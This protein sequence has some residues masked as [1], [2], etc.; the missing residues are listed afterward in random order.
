M[1]A[2]LIPLLQ[3]QDQTLVK[4]KRF[5]K[6]AYIGDP[7]N[8]VRI[9]NELE[10]DEMAIVDIRASLES[11]A[12]DMK[13]LQTLA[14]ECFMPLAYGGGIQSLE[15]AERI[16][17]LGFEKIIL[18]S[19]AFTRPGLMEAMAARLGSQSLVASID[20]KRGWRGR[21]HVYIE[22]GTRR[23]PV[24]VFSWVKH[25]ENAG[26]GEILLTAI[27][28][29]GSWEGMDL[30]LIGK[31]SQIVH[32]PIM[33]HGGAGSLDDICQAVDAGASSIAVGNLVVYQKKGMGVLIH[34][35]DHQRLKAMKLYSGM[36]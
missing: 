35:P 19:A 1:N 25:I 27:H 17:A 8:T 23:L 32:L 15:Q 30:E 11:R 3:V 6:P 31:V 13:W 2:R 5:R 36:D 9:F 26:A 10:V 24:D 33:A 29:E 28:R 12:P 22:S 7:L 14:R 20:V 16:L 34:F 21:P 18:G 4:T